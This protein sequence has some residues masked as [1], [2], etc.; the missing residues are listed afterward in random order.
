MLHS[1]LVWLVLFI[2]VLL[3]CLNRYRR[4]SNKKKQPKVI[5]TCFAGRR[6][7]LEILLKYI[8]Y[9]ISKG[10]VQECHL[11]NYT[12]DPEDEIWLRRN[13]DGKQNIRVMEVQDKT[14]WVEYYHYYTK[15]RFPN[16]IIIKCDDDIMFVD[17]DRF[18]SF[19]DL[20]R[21][22]R[23]SFLLFPSII[24]NGVCAYVQQKAGVLP[25]ELFG[26]LPYE[27]FQGRLWEDG[28]L[29]IK[30]HDFFIENVKE[31]KKKTNRLPEYKIKIGDRTSI[32]FFAVLSKD[33]PI[34][35]YVPENQ[36]D[37]EHI[38]SVE[39]PRRFNRYNAIDQSCF[40]S[41]LSFYRQRETGIHDE[42]GLLKKYN[43]LAD[44]ILL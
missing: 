9:F 37:D 28:K 18:S 42:S 16:H 13:F 24:N 36:K 14:T 25:E 8:N 31:C 23:H 41:H 5:W 7:Y 40:V 3:V 10:M 17:P 26:L 39:L 20:R 29:A 34:F 22:D 35:Q 12:R 4:V 2:L 6:R 44:K 27:P 38:V 33:L 30:I 32:N 15:E 43:T 21:R 19:L 1:K 11:W